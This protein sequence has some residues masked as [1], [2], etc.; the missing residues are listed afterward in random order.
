M[1]RTREIPLNN[2][3]ATRPPIL[4]FSGLAAN[5]D[6]FAGQRFALPQLQVVG[7]KRPLDRESLQAYAHRLAEDLPSHQPMI[8]GGASFGGIVALHVAE[9]I[10]PTLVVLIGSVRSPDELP[11]YFKLLRPLSILVTLI[12]VRILQALTNC[13][14]K[15]GLIPKRWANL[16]GI[17]K[18]FVESDSIV[19]KWS[20]RQLLEWR[21]T[22]KGTCP[23][24]Q[25][26]GG[27]DRTLPLR[28]TDPVT[29]IPKGGHVISLSHPDEVTEFLRK[30]YEQE[31]PI[32]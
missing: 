25:I 30:I 32:S 1:E 27:R 13:V 7:W 15:L 11:R 10:Q 29:I 31:F 8:L 23:I 5:A 17:A 16:A 28:H 2:T 4:L 21:T 19:F 22:P 26:H 18:Q 24:H 3:D 6:V 14:L 12:P 9:V 20:L